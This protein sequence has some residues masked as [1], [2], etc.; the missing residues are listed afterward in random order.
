MRIGLHI[1]WLTGVTGT[2]IVRF[3]FYG[4]DVKIAKKMESEGVKGKI[5]VTKKLYWHS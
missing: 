1:E 4:P 3:D 2:N 5:N